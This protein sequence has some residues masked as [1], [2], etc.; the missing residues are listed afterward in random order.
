L[1]FWLKITPLLDVFSESGASNGIFQ[2][3]T[4]LELFSDLSS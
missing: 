4:H 3:Q 2:R 1:N